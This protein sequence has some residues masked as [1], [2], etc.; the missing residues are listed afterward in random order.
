MIKKLLI[1]ISVISAAQAITLAPG[2]SVSCDNGLFCASGQTCIS[3]YQGAGAKLA[4]SPHPNAVVC[5]DKRFSCPAGSTCFNELC[6]PT[7]GGEPFQASTSVDAISVGLRTYGNGIFIL[8]TDA[9]GRVKDIGSDICNLIN[10]ALPSFC[11]CG[12]TYS[13]SN[14]TCQ[15]N[16]GNL[17]NA[18]INA[19]FMP[20]GSPAS[21]GY[22]YGAGILGQSVASGGQVFSAHYDEEFTIPGASFGFLGTGFSADADLSGDISN[23]VITANVGLDVCG[24]INLLFTTFSGCASQSSQFTNFLGITVPVPIF[25]ETFD[26]SSVCRSNS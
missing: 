25:S 26:F 6:T 20:C 19:W 15:A 1:A 2:A 22:N 8:P 11:N 5:N 23:A 14:V 17:L 21:I 18:F 12:S 3:K 24:Q 4:C 16:V 7:N 13:G 10:P 9:P